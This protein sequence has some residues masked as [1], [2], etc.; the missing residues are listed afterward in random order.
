MM[1]TSQKH[2]TLIELLVVIAIIA[3]LAAMLLPALQQA[4]DR[5]KSSSCVNNLKQ[6]SL[7]MSQYTDA[8]DYYPPI[9]FMSSS[10]PLDRY[11]WSY[12]LANCGFIRNYAQWMCPAVNTAGIPASYNQIGSWKTRMTGWPSGEWT[13]KY[14]HYGIN[15]YG[16]THDKL[17]H[18]GAVTGIKDVLA[19]RPE[20]MKNPSAKI[21]MGECVM[22]AQALAPF[23][24]F[25][26]GANGNFVNRHGETMST[27]W[28]DGHVSQSRDLMICNKAYSSGADGSRDKVRRN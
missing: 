7:A 10:A 24:L 8:Y 19:G 5:A 23:H 15:A 20:L 13:F 1:K 4:R 9:A 11:I 27:L 2:F 25:D 17:A 22:A 16:A 21:L 3:I 18:P 14:V 28:C 26:G 12:L 6:T